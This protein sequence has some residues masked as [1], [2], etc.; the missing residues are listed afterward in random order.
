MNLTPIETV[1]DELTT[2]EEFNV[3]RLD[4][5]INSKQDSGY[6]QK[7]P[8]ARKSFYDHEREL[9]TNIRKKL[10]IDKTDK[11]K[12]YLCVKWSREIPYGRVEPQNGLSLI[13]VRR[14]LRHTLAHDIY[15]D[16][17]VKNCH[18]E[19]AY[20]LARKHKLSYTAQKEYITNR[21]SVLTEIMETYNCSQDVAK[22]FVISL[23]NLGTIDGFVAENNLPNVEAPEILID[24][25]KEYQK[26][27][28]KILEQNSGLVKAVKNHKIENNKVKN[29][30]HLESEIERSATA[31]Y[32]QEL[33]HRILTIIYEYCTEKGYIENKNCILSRDGIML[34]KYEPSFLNE[35]TEVVSQ[36]L[37]FTLGFVQKPM[38]QA[39]EIKADQIERPMQ[40]IE[41]EFNLFTFTR[42]FR[43]DIEDLG[44]KYIDQITTTKSFKYFNAFHIYVNQTS[45]YYVIQNKEP[46]LMSNFANSF[47]GFQINKKTSFIDVYENLDPLE[48]QYFNRMEFT[49]YATGTESPT[50]ED[51]FNLFTGFDLDTL[52]PELYNA[53][54]V[55]PFIDHIKFICNNE[56]K[57]YEYVLN[58]IAHVIQ[59]PHKKTGVAILFYS[60]VEGIGKNIITAA[61]EKLVDGYATRLRDTADMIARFNGHMLG[62]LFVVGDEISCH[63]KKLDA[64]LKDMITRHKEQ[65]E[66]KHEKIVICEDLKNYMFSTNNEITI[67]TGIYDRRYLLA[68]CPKTKQSVEYYSK[69]WKLIEDTEQ[70]KHVFYYFKT[71][72]ISSFIVQRPPRTQYHLRLIMH[73]M[74]AYVQYIK[75][76]LADLI[77]RQKW[78]FKDLAEASREYARSKMLERSF[79]EK[80]CYEDLRTLFGYQ[81][82]P[83]LREPDE[84][85]RKNKTIS[86]CF[87]RP[88][89]T[90][91][92][93]IV[94]CDQ[95]LEKCILRYINVSNPEN[96]EESMF[97]LE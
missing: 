73:E 22:M 88:T 83:F 85:D 96:R 62:K 63:T 57:T 7:I 81:G 92:E 18:P 38:D 21:Q 29:S 67:K 30:K 34:K 89:G 44:D 64:Q 6:L 93:Q 74:P 79:T 33:E 27:S 8:T 54:I 58:W 51:I 11:N 23:L 48:R 12:G 82:C 1:L 59:R 80:K 17:D 75:N 61:I 25:Q 87:R 65:I 19:L 91:E 35:F 95:I 36:K 50:K 68:E 90:E 4:S 66:N 20:Q 70:M 31:R 2:L 16:F 26:L 14:A 47:K 55:Q 39:F 10:V 53:E 37:G 40:I 42:L 52:T 72:D 71:R 5:L 15:Y 45:T 60:E 84:I 41:K 49:P 77:Q 13:V 76:N 78:T 46:I 56:T 28:K 97:E 24:L 86:F 3:E 94:E 32:F 9:L 69:L 43:A